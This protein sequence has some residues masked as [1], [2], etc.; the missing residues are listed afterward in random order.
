M[1]R[2]IVKYL[3]SLLGVSDLE[4]KLVQQELEIKRQEDVIKGLN[5]RL[6]SS[7]E[8]ISSQMKVGV[9]VDRHGSWAVVCLPGEKS[10]F[11]EFIRLGETDIREIRSFLRQFD[12]KNVHLDLPL[13]FSKNNFWLI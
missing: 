2:V 8:N 10:D 7:I 11:I 3:K 9:D 13:S 1:K 4:L 6:K 5:S 12:K